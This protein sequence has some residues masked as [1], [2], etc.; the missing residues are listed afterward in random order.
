MLYWLVKIVRCIW[1]EV[2]FVKPNAV[3]LFLKAVIFKVFHWKFI[4]MLDGKT[5]AYRFEVIFVKSYRIGWKVKIISLEV[6]RDFHII[7]YSLFF[8]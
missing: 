2:C 7:P 1:I 5:E 3:I 4:L 6:Y 8:F